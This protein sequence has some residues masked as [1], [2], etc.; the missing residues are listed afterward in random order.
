TEG[1]RLGLRLRRE[2]K[3]GVQVTPRTRVSCLA[4]VALSL[5]ATAAPRAAA[6]ES[7]AP[8]RPAQEIYDEARELE[9]SHRY[10]EAAERFEQLAGTELSWPAEWHRASCLLAMK[11]VTEGS[12]LLRHLAQRAPGDLRRRAAQ[13]LEEV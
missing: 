7:S 1:R 9:K 8:A 11:Q 2:W 12:S 6:A 13:K 5:A 3:G 10:E 4:A